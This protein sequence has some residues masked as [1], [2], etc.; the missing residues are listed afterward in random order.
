MEVQGAECSLGSWEVPEV[1]EEGGGAGREACGEGVRRIDHAGDDVGVE[2][3]G[4][5]GEEV[6]GCCG[7]EC[8]SEDEV[9]D[10][11]WQGDEGAVE[12]IG[13]AAWHPVRV[14]HR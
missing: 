11:S 10:V 2:G 3:R 14:E 13:V 1:G 12:R 5:F 6:I 8:C 7:A 4:E 9:Q